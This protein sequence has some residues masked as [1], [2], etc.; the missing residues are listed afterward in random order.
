MERKVSLIRATRLNTQD[1]IPELRSLSGKCVCLFGVGAI[2][3]P[4]CLELARAGVAEIRIMD[5]D[6]LDPGTI[7]RWPLGLSQAGAP[8][9][10]A[11]EEFVHANYPMT[12]IKPYE[13]Q[14]GV[15][16]RD[17]TNEYE[18]VE[19][20]V[21]GASLV[22][23]AT[24]ETGVQTFTSELCREFSIPYISAEATNGAWGGVICRVRP[25]ATSGCWHCYRAALYT[26]EASI[27]IDAPPF[28]D[29][30][31]VQPVGCA[32]PTFTGSG[33]DL[34]FVS[35][36][37][38]RLA[39]STMLDGEAGGYPKTD[40]DVFTI[41]LREDDGGFCVPEF[42]GHPLRRQEDCKSCSL[43]K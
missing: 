34:N 3:A 31:D 9:V 38:V 18:Y 17:G 6:F 22:I 27:K 26:E 5:H 42:K 2:G 4:I 43:S 24:A 20:F 8:K 11:L 28:N 12:T 40:D 37:T 29:S 35:M 25:G 13:H 1:R 16:P 39:V 32:D 36:M 33:F 14:L 21:S 15:N 7:A 30:G 23:D 41:K 10:R 19:K